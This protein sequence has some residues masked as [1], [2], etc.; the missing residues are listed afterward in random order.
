MYNIQKD[1]DYLNKIVLLE[2]TFARIVDLDAA[3]VWAL[4]RNPK[5]IPDSVC[6]AGN[7]FIWTTSEFSDNLLPPLCI[8][9]EIREESVYIQSIEEEQV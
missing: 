4:Q 9:Y 8:I 7:W 1:D 6:I 3:I 5:E 2:Q